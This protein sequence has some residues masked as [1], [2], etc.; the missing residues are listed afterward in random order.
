M[1]PLPNLDV[2]KNRL[3][4]TLILGLLCLLVN[5]PLIISHV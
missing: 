4:L 3:D 2:F 5:S 1:W